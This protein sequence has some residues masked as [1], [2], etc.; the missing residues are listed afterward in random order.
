[1]ESFLKYS[2]SRNVLIFAICYVGSRDIYVSLFLTLFF[3][4]LMDV[5]LN[6]DCSFCILPKSFTDYHTS[7]LENME[8]QGPEPTPKEIQK[9]IQVLA[10]LAKKNDETTE[11]PTTATIIP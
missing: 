11:M 9:A 8:N 2:F 10:K 5:L 4:L 6:E 7:K 3:I 1:M